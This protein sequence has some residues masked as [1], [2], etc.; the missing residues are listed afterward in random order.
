[1]EKTFTAGPGYDASV[2][3]DLRVQDLSLIN[4][5]AVESLESATREVTMQNPE[6]SVA[7]NNL[8]FKKQLRVC[9]RAPTEFS[10]LTMGQQMT[11]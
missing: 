4:K 1:M 3:V 9:Y 7:E 2:P 10:C 6:G 5:E 8:L 11:L